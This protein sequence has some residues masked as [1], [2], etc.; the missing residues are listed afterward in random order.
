MRAL[1]WAALAATLLTGCSLRSCGPTTVSIRA[2][3]S[4]SATVSTSPSTSPGPGGGIALKATATIN[5]RAGSFSST[6]TLDSDSNPANGLVLSS[7][8]AFLDLG[9]SSTQEL[10]VTVIG[11]A[12][13]NSEL[14]GP[15]Q[16]LAS[17]TDET[18]HQGGIAT[19]G[20][21]LCKLHL[22]TFGAAG[23]SGSLDCENVA[24]LMGSSGQVNFQASIQ[25]RPA[26]G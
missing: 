18:T 6:Y 16:V 8:Q 17:F 11:G 13:A 5:F 23:M 7:R 12:A 21:G 19:A 3:P 22:A 14:S 4:P 24:P 2:T 1:S 20:Q 25:A 26:A 15:N 9:S 10:R